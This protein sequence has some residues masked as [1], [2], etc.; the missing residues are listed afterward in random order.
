M[1]SES[2]DMPKSVK[3]FT[4]KDI[5]S[6]TS[7]HKTLIGKGGFGP[8]YRGKLLDGQEVA[9]KIRAADSKQ[10]ASEFLNEVQLLSRL[11]HR[12]LVP[13]IGYCLEGREQ[14]L[15]YDYMSQGTLHQHLHPS[16]YDDQS[17]EAKS[18]PSVTSTKQ[19]LIW[20]TRLEI[21]IDAARGI[22]YLHKDCNPA[23]IH[24]DVKS[25][26]ILLGDKLQAKITD[27]GISKQVSE[28]ESEDPEVVA[29]T[30]GGVSTA[31]KGTFGYLDPELV[32]FLS[33]LF[34]DHSLQQSSPSLFKYFIRRKLTT[35]SDVYSFG[36]VLLELITGKRPHSLDFPDSLE[37]NLIDW[38]Q[39]ALSMN[40]HES[41]IDP[42]LKECVYN[43]EGV[44]KVAQIALAGVS[45]SGGERPEMGHIVSILVEA[46]HLE[47]G[48]SDTID[49]Q[50]L[51][52]YDV[53]FV[54]RPGS[55]PITDSNVSDISYPS[56]TP[57]QTPTDSEIEPSPIPHHSGT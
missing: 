9:V 15:V 56:Q 28:V 19:P 38:V 44:R 26:N 30:I 24:R 48:T 32:S 18:D 54:Q 13:L 25:S 36:I 12:N 2:E 23:V 45:S 4:W 5:K 20:K 37:T 50:K 29:T 27:L 16:D 33:T 1:F 17:L 49:L 10:G 7:N 53:S 8:V 39:H 47:D 51:Q 22:E 6:I 31:I 35:K 21:A 43:E 34:L 3:G 57:R 46:L 11:H 55:T 52:N 41:I 42:A 14:V 40:E